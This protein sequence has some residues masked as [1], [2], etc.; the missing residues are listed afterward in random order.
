MVASENRIVL[1]SLRTGDEIPSTYPIS[2]YRYPT[3]VSSL[4][5][6]NSTDEGCLRGPQTQGL[7]V[8][9]GDRVDEWN[10]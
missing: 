6:D 8:C 10:W 5:F 4:R 7:L 9:A 1:F 3:P 2:Q